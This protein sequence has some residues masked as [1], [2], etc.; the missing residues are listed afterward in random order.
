MAVKLPKMTLKGVQF[1]KYKL[2]V[3]ADVLVGDEVVEDYPVGWVLLRGQ[4]DQVFLKKY[5][6]HLRDYQDALADA[7]EKI[8]DDK[9]NQVL[10]DEQAA[11]LEEH[12]QKLLVMT[13]ACAIEDW[14]EEFFGEVFTQQGAVDCF[15]D[16]NNN[17]IYN[18]IALAV[19]ERDHFLPIV[20]MSPTN[21]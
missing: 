14:D 18:Q 3:T 17:H 15:S 20:S 13:V 2:E 8:K 6:P 11:I 16:A 1:R 4:Q 19:R 9:D 7:Q 5:T 12:T 10:I 21:G